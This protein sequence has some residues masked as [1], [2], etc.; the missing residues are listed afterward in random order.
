MD[1]VLLTSSSSGDPG[2]IMPIQCLFVAAI[3]TLLL[4]SCGGSG[5]DGGSSTPSDAEGLWL[6]STTTNRTI[7]GLVLDDGSFYILYS[8]V[9]NAAVL[10]GVVQ[11]SGSA[12]N[13]KFSSSSAVDLNTE[14][15]GVLAATVS[16]D[17]SAK[18]SFDGTVSH[19]AGAATRFTSAFGTAYDQTPS[20]APLA[21]TFAGQASFSRGNENANLTV[22][23]SGAL[24]GSS[25]SGCTL[26]GT[27]APRT[28][29]NVFNVSITLGAAPCAFPNQTMAGVAYFDPS[30][31]RLYAA[32][33]NSGRTDGILFLG[34]KP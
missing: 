5:D 24:S 18:K 3:S 28:R 12:T 23:A 31:K 20:L 2:A 4:V 8:R 19:T 29:G 11:G 17:Y 10:G 32:T 16:S 7:T 1:T 30:A 26:T 33:L 34:V 13:G 27:V 9:G 21:G 14:G 22:A 15:A 6:G 25:T